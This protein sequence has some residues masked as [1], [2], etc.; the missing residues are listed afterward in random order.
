[1][2]L[3]HASRWRLAV[4]LFLLVVLGTAE[5]AESG[6]F[7]RCRWRRRCCRP[8]CEPVCCE[9]AA[10][11][12]TT[13][14]AEVNN[15][16]GKICPEEIY[17]TIVNPLTGDCWTRTYSCENC[18]GGANVLWSNGCNKPL[19]QSCAV[20]NDCVMKPPIVVPIPDPIWYFT[21]EYTTK[22]LPGIGKVEPGKNYRVQGAR[23]KF[24]LQLLDEKQQ[25]IEGAQK[26]IELSW[27]VPIEG[28][29]MDKPCGIGIEASEGEPEELNV[30]SK[31]VSEYVYVVTVTPEGEN[32]QPQHYTVML[33]RPEQ[34]Q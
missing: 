32:A 8:V 21:P 22:G 16:G 14:T 17:A 12:V 10:A 4:G 13:K 9:P 18:D 15:C 27:I 28:A 1:M 34:S 26:L 19:P 5:Y 24:M 23:Q 11:P 2:F 33:S 7:R 3:H 25:T 29:T 30:L 31:R 6:L 20:C